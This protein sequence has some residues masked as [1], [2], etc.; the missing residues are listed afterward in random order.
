MFMF[1]NSLSWIGMVSIS[2]AS[3][4]GGSATALGQDHTPCI[5][6]SEVASSCRELGW[7]SVERG[8]PFI[9]ERIVKSRDQSF[10]END[11]IARDA[12]GRIYIEQH[13]LSWQFY[14]VSSHHDANTIWA[15]GTVSI[16]D[17]FGGRSIYLEPGS[18]TA[19]IKQSCANVPPFQQS[20]HPYSYPLTLLLIL[21]TVPSV[22]VEDLGNKR[23]EGFQAH[24]I[25]ITW[26]G[27]EK[28]GDW[29]G[30]PIRGTEAWRS[31]E[32]G[33]TLLMV[34]SDLRNKVELRT[35]LANIRTV[36]PEG[37]LFE[38]PPGYQINPH[39]QETSFPGTS[40]GAK[41]QSSTESSRKSP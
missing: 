24:G 9:A 6:V 23:I 29:N 5:E 38:V 2:T 10:H 17:C 12:A 41:T 16:F 19:D 32:L 18:R 39:R 28:D 8:K 20:N 7:V 26:L 3:L 21:K 15:L 11:L 34:S 33:A 14:A 40:S 1:R 35:A 37:S 36:E 4:F 27:G 30:R 22:S 31:D 25:R 13:D